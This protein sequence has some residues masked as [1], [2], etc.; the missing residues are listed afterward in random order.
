MKIIIEKVNELNLNKISLN[1][2]TYQQSQEKKEYSVQR[3]PLEFYLN[4]QILQL[5][6]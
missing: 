1:Y 3:E 2:N 6:A 5:R 4:Q